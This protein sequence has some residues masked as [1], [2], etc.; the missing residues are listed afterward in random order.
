MVAV[1]ARD[2]LRKI[3]LNELRLLPY[4]DATARR[5]TMK[6][7]QFLP[8][9]ALSLLAAL[10]L[11]AAEPDTS[12]GDKMLADYFRR[13]TR[14]LAERCLAEVKTLEDWIARRGQY[15]KQLLEMLGLEPLPPRTELKPVITGKVEREEF[16][17]EKLHFQSMPGLYVTGNMYLPKKIE[18]PLPTILYVCGHAVVKKDGVSFGNKAGYQH[19]G[20]WF[21]RNGYACLTI[22]TL[23]LG[24]IEGLHHGTYG[25]RRKQATPAKE[26]GKD[27]TA[28]AVFDQMWWWNCRG[29]TPAG[30][31]AW[32]CV[33]ALDYLETRKE[34][35]AER[36]GVT[37]RS[38]G[39]AYSWWIAAIDERIKAAVPV[40]G[41]TDLENHVVDG[42]VEGHCDCMYMLNTYRWDYAQVAALV[43]PR[44]LLISNTDK[45][46][47]FPLEGVVRLHR[48]VR[49]IYRLYGKDGNLG[50]NITEGPHKDTQEL[51]THAF[52]WFNRFLKG[53]SMPIEKPAKKFFEPEQLK[54]FGSST[55]DLPSDERNTTIHNTFVPLADV[56]VP[57][58]AKEWAAQRDAMM[59]A[60][61]EKVFRGWPS[62]PGPLDVKQV[63]SVARNGMRF[64]AYDFTSQEPFRLRLYVK[65]PEGLK[66]FQHV[67]LNA[68]GEKSWED[69]VRV[70]FQD[71]F[72]EE[73]REELAMLSEPPAEAAD[74]AFRKLLQSAFRRYDG[75]LAHVAPR[76][77]GLTAWNPS[78]RKQTQI[79]RRFMLLG[80][81][82]DAMRVYDVCRAAEA[83][84]SLEGLKSAPLWLQGRGEMGGIALY[85]SLFTPDVRRVELPQLNKS[86]HDGPDF[87]NVLRYLDTPQT[88]ALAAERSQVRIYQ[89]PA[90]WAYPLAVAKTLK[91]DDKRLVFGEI[92]KAK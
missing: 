14:L 80:Q 31:E 73:L 50:L 34:V 62:E 69:F 1:A 49:D 26:G 84:R 60:L 86:H 30:V 23:Q 33:R 70:S 79:R 74:P 7:S 20:A 40:A 57:A 76:G 32:N 2:G 71:G 5:D 92:K 45:D 36:I 87:L 13:E 47:I 37:G 53:E 91:W 56:K 61:K 10:P 44:P 4:P 17:V 19:H 38:G 28:K 9:L 59:S 29:Y 18:R 78:E 48:K 25:V 67:I 8:T 54:V 11:P 43:A 77:V 35:D 16:V 58:D 64:S 46:S 21:A 90:G 6:R 51:Q 63:F 39:G 82:L 89:D 22:D 55:V 75:A 81:T 3:G 72:R 24:E 83:L 52:V 88:V 12:R 65:H 41:I 66:K 68:A 27:S 85:A 42:C 15:R